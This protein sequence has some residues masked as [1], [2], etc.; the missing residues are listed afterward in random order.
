[1]TNFNVPRQVIV[2]R[3][4]HDKNVCSYLFVVQETILGSHV[5]VHLGILLHSIENDLSICENIIL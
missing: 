4:M 1:M 3:Y 2:Y 5:F